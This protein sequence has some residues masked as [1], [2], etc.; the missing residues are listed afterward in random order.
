MTSYEDLPE[1]VQ[2][3]EYRRCAASASGRDFRKDLDKAL[4]EYM[5]AEGHIARP[6]PAL[7]QDGTVADLPSDVINNCIVDHMG[8]D[9]RRA[10]VHAKGAGR[11]AR[12]AGRLPPFVPNAKE[13]KA[14]MDKEKEEADEAVERAERAY[15]RSVCSLMATCKHLHVVV[16]PKAREMY[17]EWCLLQH[18]KSLNDGD[19]AQPRQ[20]GTLPIQR[21]YA[22]LMR[23]RFE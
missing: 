7:R 22:C 3:D 17:R 9:V 1:D 2:D 6:G 19:D 23:F 15:D 13:R 20:L 10:Q 18:A 8:D 4:L 5:Y 12:Q 11:R 14:K 16:Y 21:V